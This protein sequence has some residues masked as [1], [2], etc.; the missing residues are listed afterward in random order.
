[1]AQTLKSYLSDWFRHSNK[2]ERVWLLA[3]I[4]FKL[5]YYENKLGLLWAL[6]KPV[7]DMLVYYIAFVLVM[8]S[9]YENFV[10]YLFCG[11]IV[12]GYF[13]DSATG[14]IK[15]L[16]TKR[17]L[18]EY[19]NMDKIEI[20]LSYLTSNFIG[21]LFNLT[22]FFIFCFVWTIPVDYHA[23]AVIPVFVN[24]IIL[25]LA[26]TIILSSIYV[27]AK[28]ITQ[29]WLIIGNIGF[30]LSP[31]LFQLDAYKKNL[32][33]L[34]YINPMSGIIIN[35]RATLMFRQ[36]P[37]WEL[38]GYDFVYAFFL[39]FVGLYLLKNVGPRASESF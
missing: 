12:W 13:I 20:Y 19:T 11:L 15:I 21:F 27:M 29:V 39:L 36:M 6:M 23:L 28:D 37:D 16:Q 34:D 2:A 26:M 9:R 1:M 7:S 24:L 4:E 17:Y 35:T 5:R 3:K 25:T 18:Y 33:Y 30:W 8:H 14:G 38:L 31:I 22:V 32:P 10:P